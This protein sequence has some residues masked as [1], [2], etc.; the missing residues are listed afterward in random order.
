MTDEEI[1]EALVEAGVIVG[2]GVRYKLSHW[3]WGWSLFAREVVADW[4]VAGACLERMEADKLHNLF[5]GRP[6][7]AK[8]LY[9]LWG[10][11]DSLPRAICEAF[12]TAQG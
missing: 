1:A 7:G 4:R 3:P 8:N 5:A 12:V 9:R 10:Y 11:H 6:G 2:D